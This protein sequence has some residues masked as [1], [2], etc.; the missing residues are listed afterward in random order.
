M[1][2]LQGG[3]QKPKCKYTKAKRTNKVGENFRPHTKTTDRVDNSVARTKQR[4]L[5]IPNDK[6][7]NAY[8]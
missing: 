7:K 3:T 8:I 4:L 6:E 1:V 5:L 2:Y